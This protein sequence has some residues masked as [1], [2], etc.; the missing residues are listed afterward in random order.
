V[1]GF[2]IP[3]NC[4][5][6]TRGFVTGSGS[7]VGMVL[8]PSGLLESA[9][10]RFLGRALDSLPGGGFQLG[11][12]NVPGMVLEIQ[13]RTNL[14]LGTWETLGWSSNGLPFT[15]PAANLPQ[16]FY[17]LRQVAP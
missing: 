1:A 10:P 8:D 4:A 5:V 3:T 2:D 15:D 6:R 14:F 11:I 7:V 17:R 16:R 13:G 9:R 12:T